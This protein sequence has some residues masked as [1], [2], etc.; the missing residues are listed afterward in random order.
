MTSPAASV[1]PQ[2]TLTDGDV[3]LRPWSQA[4]VDVARLQHDDE[5]AR[6]FGFTDVVPTAQR[7][8]QAIRDW[9]AAYADGRRVVSFLVEVRGEVAGTVE[10]RQIADRDR[11]GHLSWAMFPR[12]RGQGH[13]SHAVRLLVDY[14]FGEL[15][16]ARVE[17]YV[18]PDNRSSLRTAS[19]AGLRKEGLV[20][21]YGET[22]GVRGPMVLM[23]RL[24][25]DPEPFSREAFTA[26]LNAGL[27][28]KRA[29]AQALVRNDDGQVLLCELVYKRFWDLPGGVVDPGE[30]PAHAV[31]REI[32]EELGV[33]GRIRSLAVVSWLPP[34]NGWDDAMLFLYDVEVTADDLARV[35]LEPREIRGIHW[36]D[37]ATVKERAADYTGRLVERAVRQVDEKAGTAYL[38]N[39]D[40]PAW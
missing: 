4:D 9:H 26:T 22:H 18:D 10:L 11:T 33:E 23:G 35:V 36:A 27:P 14:A 19:R 30:S 39:G 6:W 40:D 7:Q 37:E 13:G 15:D 21:G 16:L 3:V 34:W 25:D 12:Y 32:R 20:R 2:P 17:A 8:A 38:E 24:V 1:P 31:L 28:T 5:I 29:I